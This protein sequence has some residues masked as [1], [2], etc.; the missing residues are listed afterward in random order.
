VITIDLISSSMCRD[1]FALKTALESEGIAP[2]EI[3]IK[4]LGLD[5]LGEIEVIAKTKLVSLRIAGQ[6]MKFEALMSIPMIRAYPGGSPFILF[7]CDLLAGGVVTREG[8]EA[9]KEL[10]RE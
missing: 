1:C 2:H 3:D 7:P 8:I 9:I 5:E 6:A 10:T 4:S